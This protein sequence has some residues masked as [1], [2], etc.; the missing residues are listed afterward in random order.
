M[1]KTALSLAVL[2]ALALG[3]AQA[4]TV[5]KIATITPLSGSNSNL[6][7]NIKNGAQLAVNEMK[8]DFAKAGCRQRPE[9]AFGA[10]GLA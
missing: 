5:V 8:A 3:S 4:A 1:K 10:F 7:L 2:S 9:H 6:G